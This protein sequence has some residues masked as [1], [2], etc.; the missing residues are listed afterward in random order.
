MASPLEIESLYILLDEIR[1]LLHLDY[2]Q[3][4]YGTQGVEAPTG[5]PDDIAAPHG[6]AHA[7][8][9][10]LALAVDECPVLLAAFVPLIAD[11]ASGPKGGLLGQGA[12]TVGKLDVVDDLVF[13]PAA[14]LIHGALA[15]AVDKVFEILAELALGDEDA[16]GRRGHDEVL[17][18]DADHGNLELVD[19]E[20]TLA[21][22]GVDIAI[23]MVVKLVGQGVPCA[24]VLP[25]A[26]I[27]HHGHR[28]GLL[29]H[30][31][32]KADLGS[33]AYDSRIRAKSQP[34][35]MR[36]AISMR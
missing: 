3:R 1:A 19:D 5:Y 33:S 2:G 8:Y 21:C 11:E 29:D 4:G 22:L 25:P 9:H 28:L 20:R 12:D 31:I 32:V 16:V 10:D 6:L 7:V 24:E 36:P 23:G 15:Y 35:R 13:A 27:G 17:G 34:G 30:L 14:L 18:S 26:R